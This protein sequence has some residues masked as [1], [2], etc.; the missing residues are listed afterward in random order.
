MRFRK[1]LFSI[2]ILCVFII[3]FSFLPFHI[4]SAQEE[5]NSYAKE[6]SVEVIQTNILNKTPAFI[7][8]PILAIYNFLELKR[9][10]FSTSSANKQRE[11]K[12]DLEKLNP[13]NKVVILTEDPNASIKIWKQIQY[14]ILFILSYIFTH[15]VVFYPVLFFIVFIILR[16]LYRLLTSD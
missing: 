5:T 8:K 11:V 7:S 12:E 16:S 1:Y 4:I 15:I 10:A 3:I 13:E 14:Y 6:V 2:T 9:I